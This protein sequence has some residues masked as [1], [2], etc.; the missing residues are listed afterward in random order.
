MPREQVPELY[1]DFIGFEKRHGSVEGIEE[2]RKEAFPFFL[3]FCSSESGFGITQQSL[4]RL[5]RISAR[6]HKLA[7]KKKNVVMRGLGFFLHLIVDIG[8]LQNRL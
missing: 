5:L 1:R 2:V 8:R 3:F 4:L 7:K 6:F